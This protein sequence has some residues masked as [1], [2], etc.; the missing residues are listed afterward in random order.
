M[1]APF[2]LLAILLLSVLAAAPLRAQVA[3]TTVLLPDVTV[4]ASRAPTTTRTAPARVTVLDSAAVV[5]SGA[6]SVAE[7]LEARSGAF[8]KRYGSGG[9][10]TL[11]LRGTSASQ[12]LVLLDG[13]RIA[14]PQL[15]QL[16]LS[17]LPTFLL[18]SVEVMHG[19]A[20]PLYGTD[21]VG[22]VVNLRALSPHAGSTARFSASVGAFGERTGGL[23]L[24]GGRRGASGL[25]LASFEQ[26]EGDYP[27]L[28][29]AT[30]PARRVPREGADRQLVSLY[31]AG[32]LDAARGRLQLAGWY[33][34]AERGLPT[35]HAAPRGERQWDESLRLW[36]D[37]TARRAWGSLHVGMLAQA[38]A[39]R[40]ANPQLDVDQTGRTHLASA[41]LSAQTHRLPAWLLTGG[42]QAG[43]GRARHPSLRRGA[44]DAY[45]GAFAEGMGA[46]G[47]LLLYPAL[48]ADAYWIAA[49]ER[50]LAVSP[51]LGLNVR[52]RD[53]R[54][55][56]KSSAG[57][58]F[59]VPT[60]N[61]RF[62]QPGGNPDLRPEHG[63]S[64]D[65]GAAGGGRLYSAEA[66]LF[67]SALHD[68]IVWTPVAGGYWAP[69]NVLRTATRGFELS[70]RLTD[71]PLGLLRLGGALLYTFTDARDRSDPGSP[72]FGAPLRYVP[73]E[74][75]KATFTA[76]AGRFA[77]DL[78]GRYIGTRHVTTDG[79][80]RLEPFVVLDVQLRTSYRM[81]GLRAH[82]AITL[83]NALDA[84]YA[85]LQNYPMPPRHARLRLVLETGRP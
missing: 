53:E 81:T 56:L 63:W 43:L 5:R 23:L 3:D 60:F 78:N 44:E 27:Y 42:L 11:A 39:L 76:S 37:Y 34:A 26:A 29:R 14:D 28:S 1:P 24:G 49:S 58:S 48:R 38:S 7:L 20:S 72:T 45:A 80:E 71:R 77:L 31:G 19:G 6:R 85:V 46:Y 18:Q 61:D 54:L 62:W 10:A 84:D 82:L 13:H 40:Y 30:F 67:A 79:S 59:R 70:G 16:D 66:T 50:R 33:T 32:R 17:L 74:Q 83:E 22:G 35:L 69:R 9:L 68:Q 8:V 25:L 21:A 4:T 41:E 15:G 65:A 75:L 52:L 73:R 36:S 57:R 55:H 64:V 2:C 47:P 12:T 51:R